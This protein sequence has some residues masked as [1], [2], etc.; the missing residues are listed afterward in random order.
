GAGS[1]ARAGG[2]RLGGVCRR[3]PGA[4]QRRG[5]GESGLQ[6]AE[7]VG[8]ERRLVFSP[9]PPGERGERGGPQLP[10]ARR[11]KL[12]DFGLARHVVESESLN[13]TRTGAL[14]GTPLYMAPEQCGGEAVDAR[15]DVYALGAT[16]YHLLAGRP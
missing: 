5:R 11:V 3:R 12:T 4:D 6:A 8:G 7:Q 10:L 14:L 2:A 1:A 15:A 13:M 9:L 16:L